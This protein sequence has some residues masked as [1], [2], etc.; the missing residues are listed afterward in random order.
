MKPLLPRLDANRPA[1]VEEKRRT[2]SWRDRAVSFRPAFRGVYLL[3]RWEHNAWLH[4]GAAVLTVAAGCW[5]SISRLE[6]CAV[7]FAIGSVLGAEAFN[8]AVESLA[9]AVH[10]ERSALVG[11]AK[12]LAAAGVLL[13]SAGAAGVG[14]IIF[15]PRL[16]AW[17]R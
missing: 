3:L 10:P 4:Q 1:T 15:A 7:V 17:W 8:T 12:D 6:W 5:W 14:L 9:D 2:F 11:R 16:L 13:V